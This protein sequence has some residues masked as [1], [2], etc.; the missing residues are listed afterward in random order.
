MEFCLIAP[1]PV[2][3]QFKRPREFCL[4]QR[5]LTDR[6]YFEHYRQR[7]IDGAHVILDNGAYEG[8]LRTFRE[9]VELCREIK[10]S[11]VVA[12]DFMGHA[13]Q[14]RY[15]A[16]EFIIGIHEEGV[17]DHYQTTMEVI[18]GTGDPWEYLSLYTTSKADWIGVPK[19][20]D[21]RVELFHNLKRA[22]QI[23]DKPHHALGLNYGN[24]DINQSGVAYMNELEALAALR[25]FT[26]CDSEKPTKVASIGVTSLLRDIDILCRKYA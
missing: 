14:S 2:Q 19:R 8:A 6:E 23:V 15:V 9:L 7:R 13:K 25:I 17:L 18:H 20:L 10:P 21:G 12:P 11:V 24:N 26:S 5:C 4:A 16:N 3:R 22:G 1:T